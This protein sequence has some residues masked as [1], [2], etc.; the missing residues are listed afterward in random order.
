VSS[1][2]GWVDE[3]VRRSS[4]GEGARIAEVMKNDSAIRRGKAPLLE[5]REKWGTLIYSVLGS[6]WWN[7]H[8][9]DLPFVDS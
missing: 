6:R 1:A 7:L 2:A 5:N 4:R 9:E 8:L 3:L